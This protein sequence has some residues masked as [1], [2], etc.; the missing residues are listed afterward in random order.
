MNMIRSKT[1]ALLFLLTSVTAVWGQEARFHF[2]LGAVNHTSILKGSDGDLIYNNTMPAISCSYQSAGRFG[3]FIHANFGYLA[4]MME[5]T[6]DGFNRRDLD[7]GFVGNMAFDLSGGAI[8]TWKLP[9]DK[10]L[11][12]AGLG[13]HL[14]MPHIPWDTGSGER[15]INGFSLG[16]TGKAV[17]TIGYFFIGMD[18]HFDFLMFDSLFEG[19]NYYGVALVPALGYTYTY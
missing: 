15:L 14:A 5:N 2:G 9:G 7:Y 16:V 11:F 18:I 19:Y 10:A 3:F 4:L 12:T 8:A 6:G 17:F 13:A 1:F